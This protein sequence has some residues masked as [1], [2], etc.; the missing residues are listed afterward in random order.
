MRNPFTIDASLAHENIEDLD[1][2]IYSESKRLLELLD[3]KRSI[4][5]IEELL[6]ELDVTSETSGLIID[7]DYA[8]RW[9]DFEK[10][11]SAKPAVRSFTMYGNLPS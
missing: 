11:R 5:P 7:G 2:S 3:I 6:K 4:E 8:V 10:L 1:L 9:V